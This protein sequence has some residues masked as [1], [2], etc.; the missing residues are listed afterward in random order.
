M[1][2][3]VHVLVSGESSI[4]TGLSLDLG[5]LL[6]LFGVWAYAENTVVNRPEFTLLAYFAY[7][8][9]TVLLV[10][11]LPSWL[12]F[13]AVVVGAVVNE[14]LVEELAPAKPYY[15]GH[16]DEER[17]EG[18]AEMGDVVAAVRERVQ[19]LRDTVEGQRE[20]S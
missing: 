14:K 17:D 7:A 3:F 1:A 2:V 18:G 11:L 10:V 5:L 15:F 6:V 8:P 20:A 9:L 4:W 16:P 19:D 12:L 13:P